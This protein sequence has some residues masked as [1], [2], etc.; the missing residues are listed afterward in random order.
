MNE[1]RVEDERDDDQRDALRPA[2]TPRGFWVLEHASDP[3]FPFRLRIYTPGRS[4]PVLSFFVQDRWPGSNQH[5]FCLR[6]A[7]VG[8]DVTI[9]TEIE[10]IPVGAL[11]RYG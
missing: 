9:G 11:Q 2:D 8:E 1:D 3:K 6:E 7:R 4:E 5:I 10:R